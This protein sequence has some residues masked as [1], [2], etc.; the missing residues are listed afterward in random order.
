MLIDSKMPEAYRMRGTLSF[1]SRGTHRLI[2]CHSRGKQLFNIHH[3]DFV[4]SWIWK[5]Q[6]LL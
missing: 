2:C 6:K 5:Y 1:G 3:A 4:A